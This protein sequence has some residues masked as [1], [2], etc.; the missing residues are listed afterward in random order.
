M[1]KIKKIFLYF[2]G[3]SLAFLFSHSRNIAY[4]VNMV[5]GDGF[6]PMN[7]VY[8][9]PAFQNG[10]PN[11]TLISKISSFVLTPLNFFILISVSFII[12]AIIYYRR[13]KNVK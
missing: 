5:D 9:P 7:T 2:L 4:A 10:H 12:G 8:G 11:Q 1:E 3:L 6:K 13:K